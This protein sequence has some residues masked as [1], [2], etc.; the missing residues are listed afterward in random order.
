[1]RLDWPGC[2]NARDLSGLPAADLLT[3]DLIRSDSPDRVDA[4]LL[5][6]RGITT[7][8][9]LR[10][11]NEVAQARH[12]TQRIA[13]DGQEDREFWEHWGNGWQ[14]GT[15][16]YYLPHL[17]RMP[18]RSLK[19]LN[20]LADAPEGA[21]LFHCGVGRDRTGLI[22]LLLLD[23]LGVASEAIVDDYM[24]SVDCLPPL[25]AQR[26]EPDHG[27]LVDAYL[28]EQGLT[29]RG[30]VTSTL[31][32]ISNFPLVDNPLRRRLKRRFLG[33]SAAG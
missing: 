18:E 24:L 16:L 25:F 21:V 15:P 14:F 2:F 5:G 33:E 26:G 10:N 28:A 22:A 19:V 23:A 9:D 30:V 20:A 17:E 13:L 31:Q 12:S 11:H 4:K 32:K 3:K 1:M 29:L 7:V 27:T 8:I 6:Q